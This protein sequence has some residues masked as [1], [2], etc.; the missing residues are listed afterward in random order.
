MVCEPM[1]AGQPESYA[2]EDSRLPGA[3]Q[4][5]GTSFGGDAAQETEEEIP[6]YIAGY[7]QQNAPDP[8]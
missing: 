2:P 4:E 7:G 5:P 6:E 8:Q 3:A 1:Q